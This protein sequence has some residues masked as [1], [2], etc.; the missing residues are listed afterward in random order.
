LDHRSGE[1][2]ILVFDQIR[3]PVLSEDPLWIPAESLLACIE[4]KSILT[5]DELRKSYLAARKLSEL[6]PFKR[7]FTLSTGAAPEDALRCFRSVLAYNSDLTDQDWLSKEW[8]RIV[9]VSDECQIER[10]SIDRVIVLDRGM[11]N[12]PSETGTD[13]LAVSSALQQW[14]IN[15]V[16]FLARENGR[17]PRFDWQNYSMNSLPG[18][19]DLT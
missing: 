15:L 13:D 11:I 14:F 9:E 16:N 10:A 3:N 5:K 1:I 18:W 12:P 4:V 17:R 2:D 7:S 6:R 19:R 8:S